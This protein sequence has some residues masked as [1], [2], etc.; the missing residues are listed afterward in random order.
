MT[1]ASYI[2]LH[3]DLLSFEIYNSHSVKYILSEVV[4]PVTTETKDCIKPN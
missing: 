1:L 4:V 2:I 3:Y